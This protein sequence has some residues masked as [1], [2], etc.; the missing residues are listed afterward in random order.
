M[1]SAVR[2]SEGE[3][4]V[5][6]WTYDG[7]VL[8]SSPSWR[9]RIWSLVPACGC[10]D[11]GCLLCCGLLRRRALFVSSGRCRGPMGARGLELPRMV[12]W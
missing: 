4:L 3:D 8:A 2:G 7:G 6:L 5:H 1:L 12:Q 11:R 9:R 10:G